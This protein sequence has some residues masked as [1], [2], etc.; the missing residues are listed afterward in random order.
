MPSGQG[1]SIGSHVRSAITDKYVYPERGASARGRHKEHKREDRG[2]RS[3]ETMAVTFRQ[4]SE[5]C[6]ESLMTPRYARG[7]PRASAEA[8]AT[9]E[10]ARSPQVTVSVAPPTSPRT[11]P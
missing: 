1:T 9:P 10:S 2:R 8:A 3:G 7:A 4:R 6:G 11:G 5:S